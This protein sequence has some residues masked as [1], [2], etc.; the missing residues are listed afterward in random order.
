M[1]DR[2]RARPARNAARKAARSR[3]GPRF[4]RLEDLLLLSAS[5]ADDAAHEIWRQSPVTLSDESVAAIDATPLGAVSAQ[6]Q[7]ALDLIGANQVRQQYGYTG[8]GYSVAIIDTGLDYNHSAFAGRYRGGWDFVDNDADPMDTNGHGTHVA[9][10]IASADPQHLGVAPGAG[11][12]AL[13][14]LGTNGSGNF[15]AVETALQWIVAHRQQYNI[16]AVNMSLGSGNYGATPYVF[17]DDELQALKSAGVFIAAAAGNSYFSYGSQQGLAFPAVDGLSV[18]VGAVYDANYG[19]V[20]WGSGARDF[21]TAAD[22]VASFSQRSSQI[23]LFAPGALITSTYLG[24][25]YATLAGTSMA[26]P[27]VAGSALILHQALD[28]L[29]RSSSANQTNELAV[30]RATGTTIVDGDDENDNVTNSGLSFKR[31]NL[32]AAIASLSSPPGGTN[33]GGGT[34]GG[35]GGGG[36]TTPTTANRAYVT[37]L[38][39]EVL[40]RAPDSSGLDYWSNALA[41]GVTSTQ[42]VNQLWMSSEHR[43]RQ[44]GEYFTTYLHRAPGAAEVSAW[45]NLFRSGYNELRT[46]RHIIASSEYSQLHA[47]NASFVSALYQDVFG[48]TADAS[49]LNYWTGRLSQGM[50][51]GSVA[52]A[53]LNSPERYSRVVDG[54]YQNFLGRAASDAD[55]QFWASAVTRGAISLEDLGASFLASQ[56]Y[57]NLSQAGIGRVAIEAPSSL[58]QSG[59][60]SAQVVASGVLWFDQHDASTSSESDQLAHVGADNGAPFASPSVAGAGAND[61]GISIVAHD[62]VFEASES[63]LEQDEREER[64]DV[65]G[66]FDESW[67]AELLGQV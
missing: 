55:R 15:G 18:A 27:F 32:Q 28:T 51:R 34:G 53:F 40:G 42:L 10:I 11:I 12:V 58:A 14:V 65:H 26:S 16:V 56:E 64:V 38:Y 17:L 60:D 57:F 35:G 47:D 22:R 43:A 61:S 41:G 19:A 24:G 2:F 13:R 9:G 67:A 25:G 31:L 52:D 20:S 5:P 66:R 50:A 8:A 45:I 59:G 30:F 44:I 6:S 4:E 37:K 39:Q 62:R 29:G 46:I 63:W 33:P 21:G 7:P 23:G 54:Y 48:R 1:P 49:G 36:V 3:R